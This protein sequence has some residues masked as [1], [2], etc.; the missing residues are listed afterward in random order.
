MNLRTLS[1]AEIVRMAHHDL[2]AIT[3]T[4]LERELI[5]RLD[6]AVPLLAALVDHG[7]D[8]ERS[9]GLSSDLKNLSQIENDMPGISLDEIV[10]LQLVLSEFDIDDPA[11]LRKVL[12]RD[13]KLSGVLDDLA[14][15]L[16]DLQSLTTPA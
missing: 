4:D 16:A 11:V 14:K 8:A 9:S 1:D 15:P 6:A 2:D 10:A 7:Y 13:Q 5:R 12:E 3:S